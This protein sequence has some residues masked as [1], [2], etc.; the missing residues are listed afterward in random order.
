MR[1]ATG[2]P[3]LIV[4]VRILVLN[5][6]EFLFLAFVSGHEKLPIDGHEIARWRPVKLPIRG[7]VIC[8]L[9]Y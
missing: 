3:R 2:K 9:S 4:A 8:P 5:Q 7:H 1:R 6:E